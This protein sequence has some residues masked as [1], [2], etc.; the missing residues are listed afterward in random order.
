M[1]AVVGR[2]IE[3]ANRDM[4][5]SCCVADTTTR[6]SNITKFLRHQPRGKWMENRPEV[7]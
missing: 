4:T 1:L 5:F 3:N 7:I 6:V 2:R